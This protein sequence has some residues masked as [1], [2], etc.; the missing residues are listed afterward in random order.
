LMFVLSFLTAKW[1]VERSGLTSTA[2]EKGSRG[3]SEFKMHL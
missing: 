2:S 1:T 3:G